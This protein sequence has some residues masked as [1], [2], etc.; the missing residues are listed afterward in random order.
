MSNP[1]LASVSRPFGGPLAAVLAIDGLSCA[2]TGVLLLAAG[3]PIAAL[4]SPTP[5]VFGIGVAAVCRGIGLF[6]IAFAA[7]ALAAARLKRTGL[8]W[9]V[10]VLNV[11]WVVGS[12]LL[13]EFAWDGLTVI[14]RI[15]IIAVALWVA[16]LVALQGASLRRARA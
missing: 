6:L 3:G 11:L 9:E 15:A 1:S 2:A 12:V 8:V 7:L 4:I 10:I 5:E 13:V 16:L 14:G